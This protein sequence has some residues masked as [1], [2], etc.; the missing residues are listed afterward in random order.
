MIYVFD[1]FNEKLVSDI[2]EYGSFLQSRGC[3]LLFDSDLDWILT[4]A[5]ADFRKYMYEQAVNHGYKPVKED[6]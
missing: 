5:L 4:A 1:D 2:R 6:K 3:E